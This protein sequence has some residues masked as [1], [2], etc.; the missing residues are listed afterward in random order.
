MGNVLIHKA[1]ELK[2]R[3]RTALEAELGRP[4][5]DDEEVTIMAFEAHGAPTGKARR[6]AARSLQEHLQRIDQGT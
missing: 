3:T 1:S 5:R 6:E 4:L 2:R